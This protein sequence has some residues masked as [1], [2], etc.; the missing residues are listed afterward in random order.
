M[1]KQ[2]ATNKVEGTSIDALVKEGKA[3]GKMWNAIHNVKQT[4]KANGFDTRL[5]KLLSTLKAQSAHDSGQIP[6]H[7]LRTHGIANIDR[8]RRSEA[9][10]FYENQAECVEFIKASKKG[11]TS[12]T[13]LQRAMKQAAKA[14]VETVA[15]S[16]DEVSNVGQY[17]L[18]GKDTLVS[19]TGWVEHTETKVSVP[20]TRTA[21][22]DTIVEQCTQNGLDLE[23]VIADLQSRLAKQMKQA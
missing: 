5:G 22:V 13:A 9:L 11:F 21:I 16:K 23:Q 2:N 4:T 20:L 7:V 17:Q 8:R 15:P 6:T 19:D 3:L 1:A 14:E 10:W 18:N 12:L